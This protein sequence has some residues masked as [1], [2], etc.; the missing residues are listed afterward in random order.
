MKSGEFSMSVRARLMPERG[1]RIGVPLICGSSAKIS[2]T[3][4]SNFGSGCRMILAARIGSPR[5]SLRSSSIP[6]QADQRAAERSRVEA[7]WPFSSSRKSRSIVV[8]TW[9]LRPTVRS[10]SG[11]ANNTSPLRLQTMNGQGST[12]GNVERSAIGF[13]LP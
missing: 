12:S 9:T 11:F 2:Q 7:G 4:R 8:P 10:T 13:G 3:W 5:S 6:L 1:V